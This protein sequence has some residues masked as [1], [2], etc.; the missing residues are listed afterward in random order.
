M[1]DIRYDCRWSNEVDRTF[2]DDFINVE[3][4]V[5]KNDY[6]KELFAKKYLDNIYGHSVLVVVYIDGKPSA[7][8]AL[9]RNDIEGRPSYQ[10]GDTCVL[11]ACRGKGVFSEMTKRAIGMLD[12]DAIIYNFPNQNSFPG[13][14]KLGW[15]LL[16]EYHMVLLLSNESYHKEHPKDM[17]IDYA[18]WWVKGNQKIKYIKRGNAYYLVHKYPRP[19]CYKILSRVNKSIALCFPKHLG[20]GLFFYSSDKET[21]YNKPFA[22]LHVV[23]KTSGNLYVPTWKI[24]AI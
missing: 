4:S 19:F 3:K 1:D 15:K 2:I 21:W 8:R 13:Y 17:D 22:C 12:K 10:P 11:E 7:A 14:I 5:F 24:D 9:W 6:S 20:L 16:H 23:S 18:N